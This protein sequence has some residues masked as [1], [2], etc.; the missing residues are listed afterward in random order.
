[1]STEMNDMRTGAAAV[2]AEDVYAYVDGELDADARAAFEARLAQDPALQ[3]ALL[4][5]QRLRQ[6]LA[7][8]FAPV[9][10]EP[11]PDRLTAL[12]QPTATVV[13]L[14]AARERRHAGVSRRKPSWADLGGI[15][16]SLLLGTLLG[17]QFLPP[18]AGPAVDGSL[19]AQGSLGQA[20]DQQLSGQTAGAVTPGLSFVAKGGAYCRS[21]TTQGGGA[22]SAGLACRDGDHWRLQQMIALP[23][24]LGAAAPEYRQ[25]AT[26]LPPALLQSIDELRQG[27]LLDAAAEAQARAGGWKPLLSSPTK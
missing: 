20:L 12:L 22:A 24:D 7:D 18:A 5:E 3:Q 27:D 6:T 17:Y 25:A 23:T 21:F 10:D 14:G 15:A 11:L 2:H 19:L 1:M 9:L 13:S 26:A 8:T 4:R 16:A